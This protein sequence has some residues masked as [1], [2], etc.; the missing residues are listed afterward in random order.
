[1]ADRE[2]VGAIVCTSPRKTALCIATLAVL[3][4]HRRFGI[5]GVS[6]QEGSCVMMVSFLTC[7]HAGRELVRRVLQQA[8]REGFTVANVHV[9]VSSMILAFTHCCV[10][11]M[12]RCG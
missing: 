5:G 2:T 11:P 9:Q 1:M 10:S 4:P 3:A 12:V 7:S 8:E 6:L